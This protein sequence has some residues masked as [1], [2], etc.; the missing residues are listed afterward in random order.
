MTK[1]SVRNLRVFSSGRFSFAGPIS[2]PLGRLGR[3]FN[4]VPQRGHQV[5]FALSAPAKQ[6]NGARFVWLR[7]FKDTQKVNGWV[8]DAEELGCR[9]LE[10]ACRLIGREVDRR[11][12]EAFPFEFL[13]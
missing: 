6:H 12:F 10:G 1:K 9:S 5:R 2:Q 3:V 8:G 11:P 13:P 4:C 7:R